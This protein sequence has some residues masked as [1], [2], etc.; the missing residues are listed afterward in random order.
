MKKCCFF[1]SAHFTLITSF[2]FSLSAVA[3][4]LDTIP[5]TGMLLNPPPGSVITS[6][7]VFIKATAHDTRAAARVSVFEFIEIFYNREKS[8]SSLNYLSP[9]TFERPMAVA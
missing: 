2:L 8:H 6:N 7:K 1:L 3:K 9:V 4:V 5:P